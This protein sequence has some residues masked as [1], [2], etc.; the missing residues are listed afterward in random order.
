MKNAYIIGIKNI[1]IFLTNKIKKEFYMGNIWKDKKA[2]WGETLREFNC[3]AISGNK[4]GKSEDRYLDSTLLITYEDGKTNT[5][6]IKPM[7][8]AVNFITTVQTLSLTNVVSLRS[9]SGLVLLKLSD[10]S[11]GDGIINLQTFYLALTEPLNFKFINTLNNR[12]IR[13]GQAFLQKYSHKSRNTQY[14]TDEYSEF[15]KF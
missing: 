3:Q 13:D 11:H 4:V 14:I 10:V 12:F 7:P 2:N 8:Y 5:M 1:P 9:L 15:Y 6:I